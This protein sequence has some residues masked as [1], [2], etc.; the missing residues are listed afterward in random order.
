MIYGFVL[1]LNL[2]LGIISFFAFICDGD[3]MCL[4]GSIMSFIMVFMMYVLLYTGGVF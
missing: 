1:V 2:V 4:L 3:T